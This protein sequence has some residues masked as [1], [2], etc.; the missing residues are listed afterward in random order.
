MDSIKPKILLLESLLEKLVHEKSYVRTR[1]N[2][3]VFVRKMPAF[4]S[5]NGSWWFKVIM[6]T[7]FRLTLSMMLRNLRLVLYNVKLYTF[8]KRFSK[9]DS[10]LK[11]MM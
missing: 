2:S 7:C 10:Y 9:F 8:V 1:K 5:T 6:K 11:N 4:L 3:S